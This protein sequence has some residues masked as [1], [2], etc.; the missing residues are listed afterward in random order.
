M[1][2]RCQCVFLCFRCCTN[3]G[4]CW[5]HWRLVVWICTCSRFAAMVGKPCHKPPIY[6]MHI[7]IY[8]YTYIYIHKLSSWWLES[9]P[10]RWQH[11]GCWILLLHLHCGNM[12]FAFISSTRLP[13]IFLMQAPFSVSFHPWWKAP[14][15]GTQNAMRKRKKMRKWFRRPRLR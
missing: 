15:W 3:W 9:H 8:M 6:H 11:Q 5:T 2:Y 14:S 1:K 12:T 4:R 13:P 7:Y 10:E